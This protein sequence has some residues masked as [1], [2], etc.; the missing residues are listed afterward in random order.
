MSDVIS[1]VRLRW[2]RLRCHSALCCEWT[3][4]VCW[5]TSFA[6]SAHPSTYSQQSAADIS[7]I[8]SLYS[9][10]DVT[11]KPQLQHTCGSYASFKRTH[12]RYVYVIGLLSNF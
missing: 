6:S 5:T 11:K 8:P 9:T 3:T 1:Y 2:A 10:H 7:T 4:D 12:V